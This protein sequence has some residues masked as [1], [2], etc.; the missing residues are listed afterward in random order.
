MA[1]TQAASSITTTTA[2]LN[3]TGVPNGSAT[4]GYFR[5]ATTN[6]G[7]CND[8]FGSRAPTSSGTGLGTGYSGQTFYEYVYTVYE[9]TFRGG[10]VSAPAETRSTRPAI[11]S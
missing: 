8:T 7:T 11:L 10:S 4:I 6:P 1:S 3:G 9:Y 5:Y 2:Y